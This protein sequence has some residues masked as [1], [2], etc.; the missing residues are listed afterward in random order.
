M[1]AANA[2]GV[3]NTTKIVKVAVCDTRTKRKKNN[4][5]A[6][7]TTNTYMLD[8]SGNIYGPTISATHLSMPRAGNTVARFIMAPMKIIESQA[9]LERKSGRSIILNPS[10][11]HKAVRATRAADIPCTL[12][13]IH[14]IREAINITITIISFLLIGPMAACCSF[15]YPLSMSIFSLGLY[16]ICIAKYAATVTT[17]PQ[18]QLAEN[19]DIQVMFAPISLGSRPTNV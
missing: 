18:T 4:N 14:K 7:T 2:S 10:I 9:I 13:V 3:N 16:K 1:P 6:K 5:T 17:S 19:H 11:K 8:I 15:I 12:S